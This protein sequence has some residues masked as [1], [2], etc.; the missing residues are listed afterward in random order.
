MPNNLAF[1]RRGIL[2][3][4]K[5]APTAVAI[6]RIKRLLKEA[7]RTNKHKLKSGFDLIIGFQG[8]VGN[9]IKLSE[10]QNNL[11]GIFKKACLS[12]DR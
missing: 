6:N 1:N 5:N 11:L 10:I 3:S 9:K 7:Y 2:V 12:T 8:A 4:K